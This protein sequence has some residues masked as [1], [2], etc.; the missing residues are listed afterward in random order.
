MALQHVVAGPVTVTFATQVVG[1][2]R[3]GVKIRIEPKWNE[4]K[5]DDYGG[6]GGAPA[7]QQILGAEVFITCELTKYDTTYTDKLMTAYGQTLA[8]AAIGTLPTLGTFVRQDSKLQVLLLNGSI[9][10]H[11]FSN[12]FVFEASEVNAGTKYSTLM[13]GFKAWIDAPS[14]RVFMAIS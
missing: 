13:L 2:T 5:S 8:S 9:R 12:A 6:E 10:D 7:D 3:D 4:V 14:T 1:Y 11:T